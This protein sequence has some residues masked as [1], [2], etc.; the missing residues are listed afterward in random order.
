MA[1]TKKPIYYPTADSAVPS[2]Y[3]NAYQ[4]LNSTYGVKYGI[5]PAD[6]LKIKT[7]NTDI[8]L[9]IAKAESDRQTAQASTVIKREELSEGKKLLLTVFNQIVSNPSFEEQD[10]EDLGM[11]RDKPPIDLNKVKP[12][13]SQITV[14]PDKVIYDWV[15]GS[16]QG[17]I[18]ESSMDGL[19][20][21]KL[22]KDFK[23]P[24]EDLR[25]NKVF[26]VPETRYMRF[27]Y[28]F[29]DVPVGDFTE[30]IKVVCDIY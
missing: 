7:H 26:N 24:F 30:P 20:F 27:R 12:V 16:L 18:I 6:I 17:I 9:K 21:E 15:K 10:A 1:N 5:D 2:F 3:D 14:L 29:N 25:K 19:N 22:D 13:I 11:R 23:S 28:M 8:P 4:K